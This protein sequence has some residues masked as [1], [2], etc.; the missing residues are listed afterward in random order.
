MSG[1]PRRTAR[2]AAALGTSLGLL[3]TTAQLASASSPVHRTFGDQ[4]VVQLRGAAGQVRGASALGYHQT[5]ADQVAATNV[6][7]AH[8]TC[9]G[10]R[11]VSLSFQVVVAGRAPASLQLGNLA[12]AS[13]EGCQQCE[14]LAVAYQLVVTSDD[15]AWLSGRG[16]G[17]LVQLRQQLWSLAR[18]GAPLEQVRTQADGL[19][20]QLT[21]AVGANLRVPPQVRR[22]DQLDRGPGTA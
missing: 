20:G 16:H 15:R 12:L 5:H 18:S 10:C 14:S 21:A 6:A 13:N 2:L 8:A 9:D 17:Q 22:S 3:L 19:M 7:L 4:R 1:R 11:A